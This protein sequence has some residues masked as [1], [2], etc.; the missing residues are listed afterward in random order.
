METVQRPTTC[1]YCGSFQAKIRNRWSR[2][3]QL[4][5]SHWMKDNTAFCGPPSPADNMNI[6]LWGIYLRW[7]LWLQSASVLRNGQNI[8]VPFIEPETSGAHWNEN[9]FHMCFWIHE[10]WAPQC[11]L[12]ALTVNLFTVRS[13][14]EFLLCD[15]RKLY[16]LF[17]SC[18]EGEHAGNMWPKHFLW[19]CETRWD[20]GSRRVRWS[21]LTLVCSE[22][23]SFSRFASQSVYL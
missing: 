21:A 11:L 18:G 10:C 6:F 14:L 20:K 17:V 23:L 13:G 22:S 1:K 16:H 8:C 12:V 15:S 7:R 3:F 9:N 4:N 5:G 19:N 2:W